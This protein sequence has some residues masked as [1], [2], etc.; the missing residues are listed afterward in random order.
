MK[1]ILTTVALLTVSSSA[2]A[3][4]PGGPNCGWGNMLF[5]GQSGT[6]THVMAS[7]TNGSTGNATF[8]M[9]FGT[10]G[11]STSVSLPMAVKRWLM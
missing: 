10:N 11:C 5:K 1:K 9:T 2:M 6:A 7:L 3:A 4:S 8:G